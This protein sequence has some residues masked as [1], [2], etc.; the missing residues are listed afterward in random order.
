M[1]AE[2]PSGK[3]DVP[4][5]TD[6]IPVPQ[7]RS[8][9]VQNSRNLP[10]VAKETTQPVH[11]LDNHTLPVAQIP[12]TAID[13]VIDDTFS[14]AAYWDV[15]GTWRLHDGILFGVTTRE[16]FTGTD[17]DLWE[18]NTPEKTWIAGVVGVKIHQVDEVFLETMDIESVIEMQEKVAD[19]VLAGENVR[20][21]KLVVPPYPN[22]GEL[23]PANNNE[24]LR[25]W[26]DGRTPIMYDAKGS[27][28]D[29]VYSPH[30]M[31]L[32]LG[33]GMLFP[34]EIQDLIGETADHELSWREK[35]VDASRWGGDTDAPLL[36][37]EG[38]TEGTADPWSFGQDP[39]D[40]IGKID[41]ITDA[42][43]YADLLSY[44][45]V[46]TESS[47]EEL[48][49][50]IRVKA[51]DPTYNYEQ[52]PDKIFGNSVK[53]SQHIPKLIAEIVN[54]NTRHREGRNTTQEEV[55]EVVKGFFTGVSR[56][57]GKIRGEQKV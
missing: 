4:Q 57:A 48:V 43:T 2:I 28:G 37:L 16:D 1:P 25:T 3:P 14:N 8:L 45:V 21:A 35:N 17:Q 54:F 5:P 38:E 36:L 20:P 15:N 29:L 42:V 12:R 40:G 41:R 46:H 49:E 47:P 9:D 7:G 30:D 52:D 56:I 19:T 53:A 24:W 51:V 32:H 33:N 31:G 39:S 18:V 44:A 13:D 11:E 34:R 26:R 23:H 50:K 22:L 55:D 27:D 10:V 6:R